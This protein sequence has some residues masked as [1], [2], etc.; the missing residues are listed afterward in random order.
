M[1]L[2]AEAEARSMPYK[3]L[4][5]RVAKQGFK[6]MI[7]DDRR[8][9][10]DPFLKSANNTTMGETTDSTGALERR[11]Y[12]I[13]LRDWDFFIHPGNKFKM[14]EFFDQKKI[15]GGADFELARVLFKGNL[16]CWH[17]GPQLYYENVTP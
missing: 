13:N 7:L 9:I 16:V 14:T 6:E 2:Q 5:N 8:I 3:I 10:K 17:C 4:D 12:S 1:S 11:Y 15:A